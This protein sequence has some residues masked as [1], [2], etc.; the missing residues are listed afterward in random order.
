MPR[1]ALTLPVFS[2]FLSASH[3]SGFPS[4]VLGSWTPSTLAPT[5]KIQWESTPDLTDA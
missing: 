1:P 2:A 5:A 4:Y 3:V